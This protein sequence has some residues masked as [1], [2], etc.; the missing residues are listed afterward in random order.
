MK[1]TTRR[2]DASNR[3]DFFELHCEGNDAGWCNCIAWW[4]PTW[5]GWGERTA[6]ENKRLRESLFDRGEYDGYL[7][8]ADGLPA[9]WCQV[10]RRDRLEKLTRQLALAPDA[11]V[12]AITCFMIAPAHR[13]TG[14]AG[15]LLADVLRDLRERGAARVEAF[16]K[17]GADLEVE[18]L[19]TGPESLF[20]NAGFTLLRD[21]DRFPILSL[22]LAHLDT[23]DPFN[24]A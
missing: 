5:D 22:D 6:E 8:Y 24:E 21:H 7:I 17:R 16:P 3:R 20:T 18:D 12:W 23:I 2:I 4:V 9:G 13:R 14:L 15:R 1:Y 19:W 10:G 11:D